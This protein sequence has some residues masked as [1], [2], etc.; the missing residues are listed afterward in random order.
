MR[1]IEDYDNGIF[2][3][4]SIRKVMLTKKWD[5]N[6]C[7]IKVSKTFTQSEQLGWIIFNW[8]L[9]NTVLNKH[10]LVWAW[11]VIFYYST[12]KGAITFFLIWN[13]ALALAKKK[14]KKEK[15]NFN[16]AQK[17]WKSWKSWILLICQV[18]LITLLTDGIVAHSFTRERLPAGTLIICLIATKYFYHQNLDIRNWTTKSFHIYI[19]IKVG[20]KIQIK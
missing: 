11:H 18:N 13:R 19:Y 7:K 12:F 10:L 9:T 5:V 3:P 20:S 2:I 6:N 14:R 1:I 17:I 16:P 8:Y 4:T 15:E